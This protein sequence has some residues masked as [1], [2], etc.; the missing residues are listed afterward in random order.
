MNLKPMVYVAG[1]IA[2]GGDIP[3]NTHR[4]IKLAEELRLKGFMT[5]CPHLSVVTEIVCGTSTWDSWL[6]YDEQILLRC[7]AMFRMEGA[8]RGA[9]REEKFCNEHGIPVFRRIPHLEAWKD[10][11]WRPGFEKTVVDALQHD[12][13]TWGD[14]TFGQSTPASVVAHFRKEAKEFADAPSGEELADCVLLLIHWAHKNGLSL[15]DEV[16]KKFTINQNRKW[17]EPDKDGVVEHIR[18]ERA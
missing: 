15:R 1:P 4:G 7:D 16:R 3:G 11:I 17:G 18:E 9:D 14:R 10:W 5:F 6:E 8:S 13:G 2:T 12:I